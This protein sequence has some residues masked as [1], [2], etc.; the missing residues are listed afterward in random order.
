MLSTL[1]FAAQ[2]LTTPVPPPSFR[3]TE[4]VDFD[5]DGLVDIVA[6][7]SGADLRL[8]SNE[9]EGRFR[10]TTA[11]L[12][13]DG[14]SGVI[15]A[16]WED[17]DG[18]GTIDVL[19]VATDGRSQL[20]RGATDGAFEPVGVVSGVDLSGAVHSVRWLEVDGD[21]RPDLLVDLGRNQVLYR[22]LGQGS[23]AALRV[24]LAG[25]GGTQP[26]ALI[27]PN[28][29]PL[30]PEVA[31]P[32]R[33]PGAQPGSRGSVQ[34][35]TGL[36]TSATGTTPIPPSSDAAAGLSCAGGVDDAASPGSCIPASSMPFIGALYPI[37]SDW[38]VDASTGFVGLG[39][40]A[41][42]RRLDVDG[43]VRVRSGGIEFPDGSVQSTATLQGPPGSDALWQEQGGDMV[44]DGGRVGIG[45]TS[46][47]AR[48]DVSG[49][50]RVG[51][52]D[53][54]SGLN[55]SFTIE[56][57]RP[58][59]GSAYA[60]LDFDN[61]D[62]DTGTT[63][64]GA[65]IRSLNALDDETGNL[66]FLTRDLNGLEERMT[67]S[68]EGLV[69]IGLTSPA[70]TLDV[71][72]VVRASDGIEFSDGTTLPS[73]WLDGTQILTLSP[74]S[75]RATNSTFLHRTSWNSGVWM[76]QTNTGFLLAP[77]HLPH[78]ARITRITMHV[79]DTVT[80]NL[81]CQV[82]RKRLGSFDSTVIG[83]NLVVNTAAG[84]TS[85][86]VDFDHSVN[87]AVGGYMI[88]V[89]PAGLQSWPG[90]SDLACM[91]VVVEWNY[92]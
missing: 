61:F 71:D 47:G 19:L 40:T 84:F 30:G 90:T 31:G 1:L 15:Q 24:E 50:T 8:L 69:G 83:S 22:N 36:S 88:S 86:S 18:D 17:F 77:L 53:N 29:V 68:P 25:S 37:S 76:E 11:E 73:N 42:G 51:R 5:R 67:I 13:L 49:N 3:S 43:S 85:G 81:L 39:T 7:D 38:Y 6:L 57:A 72:G 78:G 23:F 41:P 64:T 32:V 33:R 80:E 56:G 60:T 21:A 4:W 26:V 10:D 62:N 35:P 48:L 45:N 52:G 46:P 20:F 82:L 74:A 12:G 58:S 59:S 44:F 92:E 66:R 2:T 16:A 87:N 91:G 28:D 27:G 89:R 9:G 79:N 34:R 70:R 55:R 54:V 14:R 75:F 63:Y 65:R